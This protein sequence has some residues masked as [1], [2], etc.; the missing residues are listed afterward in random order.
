M[1]EEPDMH[2]WIASDPGGAHDLFRAGR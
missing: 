2:V 1:D